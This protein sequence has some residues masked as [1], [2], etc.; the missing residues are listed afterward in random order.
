MKSHLRK[1]AAKLQDPD[2]HELSEEED[3]YTCAAY[4]LDSE[5]RFARIT[6]YLNGVEVAKRTYSFCDL[7]DSALTDDQVAWE[8]YP[9]CPLEK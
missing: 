9:Q 8:Y 7:I 5:L 1:L 4:Q 6:S 3:S 2:N